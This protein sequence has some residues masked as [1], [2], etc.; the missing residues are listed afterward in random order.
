GKFFT[1]V[2]SGDK[3]AVEASCNQCIIKG[4]SS[5]DSIVRGFYQPNSN[6]VSHLKKWHS[7]EYDKY[8]EY[9]KTNG[10]N[11]KCPRQTTLH[12]TVTKEAACK[13]KTERLIMNY[14][15]RKMEPLSL[16]EDEAF[17]DLVKGKPSSYEVGFSLNP[18]ASIFCTK[19][20]R[21]RINAE[22]SHLQTIL[23]TEL[24]RHKWLCCTADVWSSRHRSFMGVTVHWIDSHLERKSAILA[25]KRFQGSHTSERVTEWLVNI[26]KTYSIQDS[27]SSI[28]TDNG[29]NFVKAF[30]D[31]GLEE[32]MRPGEEEV[33]LVGGIEFDPEA[34]D[35][36]LPSHIRC[37]SHTISLVATTD[38]KR[39]LE[40]EK[41][42]S[43]NRRNKIDFKSTMNSTFGK[44]SAIWN[45]V[46][47]SVQVA[48]AI[49]TISG[50]CL[51]QP[52]A[53]RWN[54]T[55]DA[56][57]CLLTLKD[58]ID[59]IC[60]A[61]EVHKFQYIEL[62]FLEEYK[63]AL[64]PVAWALDK[65]QS[66][67]DFYF[68]Y[69]APVITKCYADLEKTVT[70]KTKPGFASIIASHLKNGISKRFGTILSL[71]TVNA[72][73]EVLSALLLPC[74]KF[75][76]V[77][78]KSREGLKTYFIQQVKDYANRH[79]LLTT[80][81]CSER[82][83]WDDCFEGDNA[84]M[85]ANSSSASSIELESLPS[86]APAERL[87]SYGGLIVHPNRCRLSDDMFEKLLLLKLDSKKLKF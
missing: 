41:V 30:K 84:N 43:T 40:G 31:Y 20:L 34:A 8:E 37:A 10:G 55:Y 11:P 79:H 38:L 56:V 73:R 66:E 47:R 80:E 59:K 77:P 72:Q 63:T 17:I 46:G 9:K 39:G 53:T 33:E 58:F 14:I 21:S 3:G 57:D 13:S 26:L 19:T 71:D 76:W 16:V 18:E 7:S 51:V 45:K 15:V 44:C 1:I 75:R 6:F 35:L 22:F 50:R 48:E 65:L 25:M 42:D 62:E 12:F 87:F 61:A 70:E 78:E 68:G 81:T 23:K 32:I 67:K 64:K 69:V 83:S 74:V 27:V 86:S 24:N 82:S 2:S 36:R 49:K 28:V 5:K 85:E 4:K 52:V 60:E 29:S 54:S